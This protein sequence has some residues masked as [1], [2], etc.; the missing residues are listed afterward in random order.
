VTRIIACG[1]RDYQNRR[2]VYSVL[3][4]AVDRL[5]LSVL[6][7]G[8]AMGADHLAQDW[9]RERGIENAIFK[10]HWGKEGKAA[11][12]IRNRR[13]LEQGKPDVVIA[14]P[15]GAGTEHMCMIAEKTGVRL[16]CIDWKPVEKKPEDGSLF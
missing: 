5:G 3:D 16:I 11:G 13:M 7:T 12:A 9:A 15:G 1:G 2:R 10:A 14:F 8:G 4:A 6:I